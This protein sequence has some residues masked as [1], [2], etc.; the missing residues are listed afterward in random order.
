[1]GSIFDAACVAKHVEMQEVVRTIPG[2]SKKGFFLAPWHFDFSESAK[3]GQIGRWPSNCQ[4]K[5]HVVSFLD[6]GLE[7]HRESI[8]TK[9]VTTD[10]LMISPFSVGFVDGQNKALIMQSILALAAEVAI[11]LS[12]VALG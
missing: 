7:S 9:F 11:S 5:A 4:Y 6:R 8:E 10:A 2:T 12:W 1:M 3:F